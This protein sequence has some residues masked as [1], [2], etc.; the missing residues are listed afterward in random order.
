MA[1][2][3]PIIVSKK[4]CMTKLRSATKSKVLTGVVV[5]ADV[6]GAAVVGASVVEASVVGT[7]VV[8]ASDDDDEE[9]EEEEEE[10]DLPF[11]PVLGPFLFLRRHST[12]LNSNSS[13]REMTSRN[14]SWSF[15][16]LVVSVVSC[17]QEQ[18]M[19]YWVS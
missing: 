13:T 8:E 15:I 14:T 7:A 2:K 5:G 12:E 17:V 4:D 3:I 19:I 18:S 9:E 6:M 10:E 16:A 11:V 1:P